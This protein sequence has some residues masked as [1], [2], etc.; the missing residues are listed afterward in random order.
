MTSRRHHML[1]IVACTLAAACT[2]WPQTGLMVQ[3]SKKLIKQR[4]G[5][6]TDPIK[7]VDVSVNSK[8]IKLSEPFAGDANWL[9]GTQIR[10][11]NAWNKNIIYVEIQFNFPE[12]NRDK[13]EMSYRTGLGNMPSLPAGRPALLLGPGDEA[14]F[15]L[16]DEEYKGLVQFI[17]TRTKLDDLTTLEL[18]IG[19]IVFDDLIGWQHGIHFRQDPTKSTRWLPLPKEPQD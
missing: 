3:A 1:Q 7:V 14:T 13:P 11:Q 4:E 5:R 18:T 19:F 6:N 9:R 2:V 17:G 15:R 12:T 8:P 16:E 10:L